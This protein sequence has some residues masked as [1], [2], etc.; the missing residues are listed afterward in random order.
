[1]N[2]IWAVRESCARGS[3]TS[4]KLK[5]LA[6]SQRS[7][8]RF[9]DLCHI[10]NSPTLTSEDMIHSKEVDMVRMGLRRS[11]S[12]CRVHALNAMLAL[13]SALGKESK[14]LIRKTDW[15]AK[16]NVRSCFNRLSSSMSA[17]RVPY[18]LSKSKQFKPKCYT[19]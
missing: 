16:H 18:L 2:Q 19:P 14:E 13:S 17:C 11:S 8:L 6:R 1:M 4:R 10:P 7:I 15:Q 9:S 3:E 5:R 12:L